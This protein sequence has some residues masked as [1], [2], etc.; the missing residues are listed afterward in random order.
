MLEEILNHIHNFFVV[1]DGVHK[2]SFTISSNVLQVDFIQTNQYYRIVGSV[3]NDGVYKYGTDSLT[4]EEF[5][6]EVWVLAV[7]P[8]LISLSST[9]SSFM[10]TNPTSPYISESFG[11]YS[12]TK[13]TQ[14]KTGL[15]LSWQDV[16]RDKLN[17]WRKL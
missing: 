4:N 1:D 2:G 17:P 15:P 9:I 7:P 3:F 6:G 13:G 8:A 14:N 10:N 5:K 12:Y 11:G 16:F